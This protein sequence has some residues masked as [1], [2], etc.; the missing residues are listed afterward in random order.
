MT[1]IPHSVHRER[2]Y[3]ARTYIDCH[4]HSPITVEQVS[5]EAAFSLYHFIRLF[6]SVYKQT[7]HQYL[8]RQRIEKAKELLRTS[9]LPI[10]EIC[11]EVGF[12]S[13]GSFSTLFRNVVGLSPSVY[14]ERIS[15][16]FTSSSCDIPLCFRIKY[17]IDDFSA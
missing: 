7:P 13:L 9:D 2:L 14:R 17:G 16:V 4:Y 10:T 12:E 1:S 3:R 6:R 5:R 15:P 11:M 8:T